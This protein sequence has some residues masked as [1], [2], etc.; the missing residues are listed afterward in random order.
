MGIWNHPTMKNKIRENKAD[1][2][3]WKKKGKK[4]QVVKKSLADFVHRWYD[5]SCSLWFS[6][7]QTHSRRITSPMKESQWYQ[8]TTSWISR[9]LDVSYNSK[10]KND[11]LK[12]VDQNLKMFSVFLL[13]FSIWVFCSAWANMDAHK[14]SYLQLLLSLDERES[15]FSPPEG[16]WPG[17]MRRQSKKIWE[18]KEL[19][20][21]RCLSK[22]QGR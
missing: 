20:C 19:C 4:R 17:Q 11:T 12:Y 18:N 16:P 14:Y 13:F 9:A 21:Q 5:P 22:S 10:K 8:A 6:S 7:V 3:D 15:N 2:T 1:I